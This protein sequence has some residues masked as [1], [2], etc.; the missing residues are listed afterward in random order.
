M[1]PHEPHVITIVCI[2]SKYSALNDEEFESIL[3]GETELE[4]LC[5]PELETEKE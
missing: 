4:E 5:P 1:Y 3:T 2:C